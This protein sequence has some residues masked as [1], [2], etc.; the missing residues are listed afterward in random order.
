MRADRICNIYFCHALNTGS[1][2]KGHMTD[3]NQSKINIFEVIFS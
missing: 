3:I 1:L 2:V